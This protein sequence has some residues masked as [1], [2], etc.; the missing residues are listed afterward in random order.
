MSLSFDEEKKL[1]HHQALNEIN[2]QSLKTNDAI[3]LEKLKHDYE[4]TRGIARAAIDFALL[5]VKSLILVNG[6]AV[7]ATLTFIGNDFKR[8]SGGTVFKMDLLSQ[9]LASFTYGTAAA[10]IVS[11]LAYVSQ[12][13]FSERP[14]A[15]SSGN[16]FRYGAT[17]IAIASLLLF[18]HGVIKAANAFG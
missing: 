10:V 17:C 9:A 16:V 7:I 11:A 12:I 14:A 15:P 3:A 6:G 2:L 4:E 8:S 1:A 18:C 5:A 13:L